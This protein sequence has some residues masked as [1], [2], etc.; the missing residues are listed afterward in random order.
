[1]SKLRIKDIFHQWHSNTFM[2]IV[3][4]TLN[5]FGASINENMKFVSS[6]SPMLNVT[7]LQFPKDYMSNFVIFFILSDFDAFLLI[8]ANLKQLLMSRI[9]VA[10]FF[11][12]NFLF[13]INKKKIVSSKPIFMLK[14]NSSI[15]IV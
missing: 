1:M 12:R 3:K 6:I 8:S 7:C 4:N 10:S 9:N 2:L 11:H 13:Y 14:T 15:S 5:L